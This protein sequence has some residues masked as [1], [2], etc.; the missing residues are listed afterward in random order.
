M[1]KDL[2]PSQS[3]VLAFLRQFHATYDH[4]PATRTLQAEFQWASQTAAIT[5]YHALCKKGHLE[6]IK[7]PHSRT[8][9][10]FSRPTP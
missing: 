1:P 2:T 3:A 10:R 9:Y 7:P 8:L 4:L 5:Y 6:A